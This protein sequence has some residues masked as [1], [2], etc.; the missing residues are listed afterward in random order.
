M[1]KVATALQVG[2]TFGARDGML[3]LGYEL[4]RGTGLM[5]RRMRS[6]EGWPRW[7][8]SRIAPGVSVEELLSSRRDCKVP[9]FFNAPHTLRNSLKEILGF[10]GEKALV[11]QANSIL[12]G[13][14][15]FFGRL[16]YSCGFPPNWFQNPVTGQKVSPQ[17]PWTRMRFASPEYGDLKFILEPSRFLFVYPLARA[18]AVTA[19]EKYAEAF[20]NS[21]EDWA[22]HNS[23]AS[24]P[25]WICGQECSLRILAWSFGFYCFL[26]STATT[27]ARTARL[28]SMIAAHAWRTAQSLGYAR[29][30][31]S[32]HLITEAVGL[33]TAGTLYP[34]LKS[35]DLWQH[36]GARFLREAVL[37]QVTPEGVSQQHSFNYQRMILQLLLWALRL[38]E[39]SGVPLD[40]CVR[41]RA[42]SAF[43]FM[44]SIVDPISGHAPNYGSNDG[45][46][47]FPLSACEY[48][49]FRPLLQ[50]GAA[51]FDRPA[52]PA[53]PWDEG[54]LWFG[55]R[56]S[57]APVERSCKDPHAE[58]GYF[59]LGEENSWALV[60]AGRYTRRPFQADQL[61]LDLWWQGLNLARD[62]G[63][64]LYNGESPWDN[65]FSRTCVHNTVTVDSRDQMRRAGRFLWL[66]W[67]QATGEYQENSSGSATSISAEHDGYK[68]LGITHRR[69]VHWLR[70]AGWV[71]TD[72]LLGSG[73]HDLRLH[74]LTPD[75]PFE[76]YESPFRVQFN[77]TDKLPIR[78]H[79]FS[80]C[81]GQHAI[82]RAG[83]SSNPETA[84]PDLPL[85]G[86][87]SPTYGELRPAVSL[88]YQTKG[89]LP[90]RF[91]TVVLVNRDCNVLCE[92]GCLSVHAE[93]TPLFTTS[94]QPEQNVPSRERRRRSR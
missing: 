42:A 21:V 34:E 11:A 44:R 6:A 20:W 51:V 57:A 69:T 38:S 23:P 9:F 18:Y 58:T 25:L 3:R 33:W 79:I 88:I 30:Q 26:H 22:S 47:I 62:A 40:D 8:L 89:P 64:Y 27:P 53:G 15:P 1:N 59:K 54:A 82:V 5:A 74:W 76:A 81:G 68:R 91:V 43:D 46:L 39:V 90:I 66:D 84:G 37:D 48:S 86:W 16:S 87:E 17:R 75:L 77:T 71:I 19:D 70:N 55:A 78:W 63:T 49:D 24:G 50:L 14:M 85:L 28:L 29:S 60:R 93:Q 67:A 2:R 32:N 4:Q 31:R 56:L 41:D 83:Q 36:T 35:A 72:D 94:L 61:H 10:E 45:S 7:D 12:E 65:S 92:E 73:E 13:H 52:F 80:S